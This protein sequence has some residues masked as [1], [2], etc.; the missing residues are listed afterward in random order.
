MGRNVLLLVLAAFGII[1]LAMGITGSYQTIWP[2]L[3]AIPTKSGPL[4][5]TTSLNAQ[6]QQQL[7]QL[8]AQLQTHPL[9]TTTTTSATQPGGK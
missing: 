3:K 5:T 4:N 6:E 9:S 2:Q 7:A 8:L 1:L